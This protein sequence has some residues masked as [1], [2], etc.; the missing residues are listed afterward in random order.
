MK[1]PDFIIFENIYD[2][3]K[4]PTILR[5][6]LFVIN[7]RLKHI[8]QIRNILIFISVLLKCGY[9]NIFWQSQNQ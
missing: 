5:D 9:R 3:L 7:K 1:I 2:F 8:R 4:I 6:I